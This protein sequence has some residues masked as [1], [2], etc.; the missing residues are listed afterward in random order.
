MVSSGERILHGL[1]EELLKKMGITKPLSPSSTSPENEADDRQASVRL[2]QLTSPPSA[3]HSRRNSGQNAAAAAGGPS[4]VT[5]RAR[6]G[7]E[8]SQPLG[9]PD[10]ADPSLSSDAR[11]RK[12]FQ[13]VMGME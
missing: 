11:L 6:L 9:R 4:Y 5:V 12:E 2:P 8:P 13:K 1:P 10:M 3:A 7:F